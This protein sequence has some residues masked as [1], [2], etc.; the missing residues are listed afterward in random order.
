MYLLLISLVVIVHCGYRKTIPTGMIA[1]A[2]GQFLVSPTDLGEGALTD[3][4]KES[5]AGTG[6]KVT[7]RGSG[8][9]KITVGGS[10]RGKVTV[11]GSGRPR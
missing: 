10:G 2:M 4:G 11:R 5:A 1:G 7:V 8:R 3:G 6:A 9:A